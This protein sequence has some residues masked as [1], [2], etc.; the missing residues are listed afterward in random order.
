MLHEDKIAK[1]EIR[2]VL[3]AQAAI[4]KS[5]LFCAILHFVPYFPAGPGHWTAGLMPANKSAAPGQPS[6]ECRKYNV[7]TGLYPSGANRLIQGEGYGGC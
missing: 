4:S 2:A 5:V 1:S 6:A 7:I 3:K